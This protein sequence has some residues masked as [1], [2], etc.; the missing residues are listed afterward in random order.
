M[1]VIDLCCSDDD[2][3]DSCKTKHQHQ[4]RQDRTLQQNQQQQ[5]AER[6]SISRNGSAHAVICLS[7]EEDDACPGLVQS[8]TAREKSWAAFQQMRREQAKRDNN[9]EMESKHTQKQKEARFHNNRHYT[10]NSSSSAKRKRSLADRNTQVP[11]Q[12]LSSQAAQTTRAR[13][14]SR[15]EKEDKQT[16]APNLEPAHPPK[17]ASPS[18]WDTSDIIS[19]KALRHDKA[20]SF[21]SIE[22]QLRNGQLEGAT[23]S[24]LEQVHNEIAEA[25]ETD[26]TAKTVSEQD[27]VE[28]QGTFDIPIEI[29]DDSD[30][31]VSLE[32]KPR[33]NDPPGSLHTDNFEPAAVRQDQTPSPTRTTLVNGVNNSA[34]QQQYTMDASEKTP[35]ASTRTVGSAAVPIDIDDD[36]DDIEVLE[37]QNTLGDMV[38]EMLNSKDS[39]KKRS[40]YDN[41]HGNLNQRVS[42]KKTRPIS[43]ERRFVFQATSS[44]KPPASTIHLNKHTWNYKWSCEDAM[45]EQERL[46]QASAARMRNQQTNVEV[47]T[48]ESAPMTT[49]I[50]FDTV[51]PNI[52]ETHPHHWRLQN[53][54]T[55]LGLPMGVSPKVIKKQ[56]RRLALVYHPDKSQMEHTATKFQRVTEAYRSILNA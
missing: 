28:E 31:V 49:T 18:N 2:E 15:N 47:L 32:A 13:S 53:P 20:Q 56:Y 8:M 22:R 4:V 48:P 35:F 26:A 27:I 41:A 36:D 21:S 29:D 46:F 43:A 17:V 38:R 11:T 14:K 52:H 54:F 16:G 7:D 51:M 1:D 12:P 19:S 50:Q 9:N 33:K 42:A 45:K 6:P 44:R 10:S 30:S 39:V 55:R 3:T 34:Q 40:C 37:T 24:P 5:R 23:T 25:L